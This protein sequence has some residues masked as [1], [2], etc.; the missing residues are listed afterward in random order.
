M[1]IAT[2]VI[3]TAAVIAGAINSIAGG[4]TL[5]SFPA[6]VWM[7][8]DPILANATNAVALWPGSL[9]AAYGYRQELSTI[10]RWLLLLVIPSFLGGA[11]GA[12]ILLRTP[13]SVFERIVPFL[14][15]GATLLLA[16]Q[17]MITKRL[18]IL[19]RAHEY[20]T[21]GWV[22]F[23]FAF[24]FLVGLYGGY[25]GAGMGIL[26]LAALGLIGLTD[27]HQMNGLKNILAVCINGIAAVYFALAGAVIWRDVVIMTIGSVAGGLLGAR[28]ARRLGRTFVR[29]AVVV[30]GLV[31]TIALLVPVLHAQGINAQPIQ[32]QAIKA[33]IDFLA[34]DLLEGREAGTRGYDIAAAYVAAQFDAAGLDTRLQ[35]VAFRTFKLD[36]AHSSFA[37]DG[38][39]FAHRKDVV[40]NAAPRAESDVDAEVVHVGFGLPRDYANVDVRGKV[41][42]FFSGAPPNLP[43]IE[44]AL[45]SDT[46]TKLRTAAE[47]GAIGVLT[48]RTNE[49][50]RRFAWTRIQTQEDSTSFRALDATGAPMENEPRIRATATL[51]PAATTALFRGAPMTL[52]ALL[53]DAD[54][55]VAHSF[56]MPARV[57]MHVTTTLGDATSANVIG[58]ARG[59]DAKLA[60]ELVVLTAHLD[61]LGLA[62]KGTDRVRNGALDNASGIAA[63]LE[64][65]KKVASMRVKP[66]RSIAFVAVTAEEKGEQGSL[67]FAEH[68][69]LAGPIVANVNM[70]ML[71]MLF[72]MQTLVA[73][74]AEHSTLGSLAKD[75]AQRAG[76]TLQED[77]QPEE[78]RF[79]RSDQ[80]SF[81][82][83]GIPAITFKGG[84]VS[85]DP[86]IDGEKLTREWLRNVYHSA[87]DNPDQKLDYASGAR[88][89]DANLNLVV[90]IANAKDRPRW[91]TRIFAP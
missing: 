1:T 3:F 55:G 12:W 64:I 54:K 15:L 6:L 32:A 11:L 76:F 70:D 39:A 25:F 4:G 91:T 63:L 2:L 18:G 59:S 35:P 58:V 89:A 90:A 8:R 51:G 31:M 38:T 57:A 67:A 81:A 27:L 22:A 69:G 52:E 17:E 41:V 21:P 30:I 75:A 86:K 85:R 14:I 23:V 83:K 44:R 46:F 62:A 82:K 47:H 20:P 49:T 79:I 28:A 56:A 36:A 68:P 80:Y 48:I 16:G 19:A 66:K 74:G 34:S 13:S 65:A 26:M 84:L 61:H 73:L 10:R 71:T 60:K 45:A 40:L 37:I 50:E 87:A 88:W 7:G 77:P 42:A 9:A 53:A 72:P 78:V 43:A 33:H 29:R 24:Q 5:I